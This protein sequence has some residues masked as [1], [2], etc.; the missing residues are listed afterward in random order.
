MSLVPSAAL[1]VLLALSAGTAGASAP[2][3]SAPRQ[4]EGQIQGL[5]LAGLLGIEFSPYYGV[6]QIQGQFYDRAGNVYGIMVETNQPSGWGAFWVNHLRHREARLFLTLTPTG[7]T[8]Q[9]EDGATGVFTC[10]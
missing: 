9:T 4:C 5:P 1:A 8:V 10:R 6:S 2:P 3:Q 7:F